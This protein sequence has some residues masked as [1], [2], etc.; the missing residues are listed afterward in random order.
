MPP[1]SLGFIRDM[2]HHGLFSFP[3]LECFYCVNVRNA[4]YIQFILIN[5]K[6]IHTIYKIHKF[7]HMKYSFCV[8]CPLSAFGDHLTGKLRSKATCERRLGGSLARRAL[9]L[10]STGRLGSGRLS[11]TTSPHSPALHSQQHPELADL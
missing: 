3:T 9:Q 7:H 1:L 4:Q 11:S 6:N 10:P 8:F 2:S 5:V